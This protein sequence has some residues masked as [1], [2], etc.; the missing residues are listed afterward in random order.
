MLE[1]LFYFFFMLKLL[2]MILKLHDPIVIVLFATVLQNK[3]IFISNTTE[4]LKKK[5]VVLDPFLLK[6]RIP[7]ALV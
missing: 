6:Q 7:S 3:F 5:F 4:W 1:L 2:I